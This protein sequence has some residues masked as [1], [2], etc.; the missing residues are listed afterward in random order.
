[1]IKVEEGQPV[2][3]VLFQLPD[4]GTKRK[5]VFR[6]VDQD[7]LPVVGA[8]VSD[9]GHSRT[10]LGTFGV[11]DS[12]GKT[13]LALWPY[14]E[15]TLHAQ[16]TLPEYRSYFADPVC[17]PAGRTPTNPVFVLRDFHSRRP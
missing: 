4:F 3:N 9:W 2:S 10:R 11:T 5:V 15:Y 16:I 7:G 17:I 14:A 8:R 12:N 13:T 1:V 6:V